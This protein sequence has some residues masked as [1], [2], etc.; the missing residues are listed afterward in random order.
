MATMLLLYIV[1]KYY[2]V[3]IL[4]AHYQLL[5]RVGSFIVSAFPTQLTACTCC[6]VAV[7]GEK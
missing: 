7:G 3:I 4:L 2:L 6:S 5:L 1:Q